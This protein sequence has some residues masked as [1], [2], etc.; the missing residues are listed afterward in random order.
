MISFGWEQNGHRSFVHD[1]ILLKFL[2]LI[3][4]LKRSH[5]DEEKKNIGCWSIV[6]YFWRVLWWVLCRIFAVDW[7]S[8]DLV[9]FLVCHFLWLSVDFCVFT[10]DE[11]LILVASSAVCVRWEAIWDSVF[12]SLFNEID[13][14]VFI[15]MIDSFSCRKL[16]RNLMMM[17]TFDNSVLMILCILL[18]ALLCFSSNSYFLLAFRVQ[19]LRFIICHL[20]V[21]V[22][23]RVS[24]TVYRCPIILNNK[25]CSCRASFGWCKFNC[26][27]HCSA[28]YDVFHLSRLFTS[29]PLPILLSFQIPW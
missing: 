12:I 2:I 20:R 18:C 11:M 8:W 1:E 23:L 24:V 14:C 21:F 4:I 7:I 19:I 9:F 26:A 28:R 29:I 10:D 25:H 3:E 13:I 27:F 6:K 15:L 17:L 16:Y 5:F 22:R